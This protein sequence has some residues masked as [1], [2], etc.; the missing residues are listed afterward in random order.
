M[1]VSEVIP[2]AV[3]WAGEHGKQVVGAVKIQDL[4]GIFDFSH[5]KLWQLCG[6]GLV[7]LVFPSLQSLTPQGAGRQRGPT[8]QQQVTS[9]THYPSW[10]MAHH[11][12]STPERARAPLPAP[13]KAGVGAEDNCRVT[14]M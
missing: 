4:T 7:A 9:C 3:Y 14:R 5:F 10:L 1:Y 6:H 13:D 11:R 2:Q 12:P 8:S